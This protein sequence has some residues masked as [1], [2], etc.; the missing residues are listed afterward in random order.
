M[1]YEIE[2]DGDSF[3]VTRNGQICQRGRVEGDRVTWTVVADYGLSAA[4]VLASRTPDEEDE[5]DEY[6]DESIA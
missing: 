5:Y 4:Q 1:T 2:W 6:D 3:A